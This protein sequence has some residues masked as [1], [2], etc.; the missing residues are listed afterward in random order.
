[1]MRMKAIRFAACAAAMMAAFGASGADAPLKFMTYNVAYCWCLPEGAT[2]T[3]VD[4]TMA[5]ARINAEAPD[6]LALNELSYG[7]GNSAYYGNTCQPA[8]IAELTGM[9]YTFGRAWTASN[10]AN[11]FGVAILSREEPLSSWTVPLP[12]TSP[13]NAEEVIGY[14]NRVLLV[15]EFTNFC[16]ATSHFD[17]SNA[18]RVAYMPI[19]RSALAECTKPV[20]F[21]GDWNAK[22]NSAVM[23]SL[24]EQ[25][26]VLSPTS[27]VRTYHGREATGGS[28]IDYIA[29]DSAHAGDFYVQR[30]YVVDDIRTSDH[31]P[32]IVEVYR[33]PAVSECGWMDESFL[34]TGRTGA[35]SSAVVWDAASCTAKLDGENVF[36]PCAA[37][38]GS[39]VTVD[40]KMSFDD[41]PTECPTPGN[42]AQAA[43]CIGTNGSFQVWTGNGGWVDVAAEGV[44]PQVDTEYAFRVSFDYRARTYSVDLLDETG[45]TSVSR[46][47][48]AVATSA[49]FPI[50][51]TLFPLATT[52]RRI[53]EVRFTGDGV[54]T[55]LHGDF[56]KRKGPMI[57][58]K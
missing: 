19:V 22:P 30:S 41:I 20:F 14:E 47:F 38:G 55:S 31:N 39:L 58:V 27:G 29:V 45:G 15:C 34:T 32:V 54:L 53:S 5:A 44:T 3:V 18:H 37:S 21:M 52:S 49:P 51:T 2:D 12:A 1:M 6:F 26:T 46:P 16:V 42:T 13:T 7:D 23:T 43:V 17:T 10:T 48:R 4:P 35:W 11:S 24:A 36:T 56:Q 50:G 9:H 33:R 8:K 57:I 40:V 25:F 28:I